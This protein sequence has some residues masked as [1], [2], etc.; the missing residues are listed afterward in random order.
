MRFLF[1]TDA[2]LNSG[3]G[4]VFRCFALARYL[5]EVGHDVRFACRQTNGN[6]NNW[7]SAQGLIVDRLTDS[8]QTEWQD[9]DSCREVVGSLRF[10]WVVVD[11]YELGATWERAMAE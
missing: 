11:H 10:D 8:V 2:S 6:L 5:L 4:H 7:L 1:R 3:T 9:F